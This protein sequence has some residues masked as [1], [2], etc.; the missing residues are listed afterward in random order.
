MKYL[1]LLSSF[2]I[3]LTTTTQAQQNTPSQANEV[4]AENCMVKIINNVNVPAE[5]EGKLMELR[6]EEGATVAKG[7]I[8][9]IIDDTQAKLGVELKM[10]EEK[11]ALLNATNEVNLT[12]AIN[13]EKLASAEAEAYKELRREGAI[14]FWE[15]EKKRLEATRAK[16]RI[17]LA[18][19]QMQ[20]AK[21][22]FKAKETERQMAEYELQKRKVTAPFDGFIETRIAQPGGWVQAGT[23]IA[24]LVQLDRLRIEGDI[25]IRRYPEIVRRGTPVTVLIFPEINRTN[26]LNRERA[27]KVEGKIDFVSSEI[28]LNSGYRV[29]VEIPNKQLNGEWQ[30]KRGMR[31]EI[32]VRQ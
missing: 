29:W 30:I 3:V 26:E 9:A 10:A 14:P 19:Q 16:L 31:G 1:F 8:L 20:I 27:I 11:E 23:P 15:L 17:D 12:D 25:D 13:N 24:T 32:V 6:F 5:V 28:D 2:V 22:Q 4:R 7:D 18:E 21:V